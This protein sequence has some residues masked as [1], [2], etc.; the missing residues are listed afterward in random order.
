[1]SQDAQHE[2]T[3]EPVGP[4]DVLAPVRDLEDL[5]TAEHVERFEA[6]ERQLKERLDD[7]PT[8]TTPGGGTE[9]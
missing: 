6:V 3:V 2:G 8:G 9:S 7:D 4:D 5:P 1:M